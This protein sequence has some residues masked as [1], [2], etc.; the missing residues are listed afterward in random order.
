M[1][2]A[3][4]CSPVAR[5]VSPSFSDSGSVCASPNSS[6]NEAW[7]EIAQLP[8][9]PRNYRLTPTR[10]PRKPKTVQLSPPNNF[11]LST[12]QNA[13]Q[14]E[15]VL[16]EE[17][18]LVEAFAAQCSRVPLLAGPPSSSLPSLRVQ[19]VRD[20]Q[21]G[22]MVAPTHDEHERPLPSS[23][24]VSGNYSAGNY[25]QIHYDC[26][27]EALLENKRQRT[28]YNLGA[29]KCSFD[30][31]HAR[32][33]LSPLPFIDDH[34]IDEIDPDFIAEYGGVQLEN[35]LSPEFPT[36]SHFQLA[37]E[38]VEMVE[39]VPSPTPEATTTIGHTMVTR[40]RARK[41]SPEAQKAP[42]AA[43]KRK[44]VAA[45]KST[46]T[47][48]GKLAKPIATS[49]VLK[50]NKLVRIIFCTRILKFYEK[51][52]ILFFFKSWNFQKKNKRL[53]FL[54]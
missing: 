4:Q 50:G 42:P 40:K 46:T 5:A 48:R 18:F 22:R 23:L 33:Q 12:L 1:R 35:E 39:L 13:P 32:N 14:S 11:M 54:T 49:T 25:D 17:D 45:V 27:D 6:S 20:A 51:I 44:T 30:E 3:H 21:R 41:R 10:R 24:P 26:D 31:E 38:P 28:F 19:I 15:R 8:V 47:Q 52:V 43:K 16:T 29:T 2:A 9:K 7:S 36:A 34:F 53:Y 37:S